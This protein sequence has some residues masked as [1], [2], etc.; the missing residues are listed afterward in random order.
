MR[1]AGQEHPDRP[2]G[3]LQADHGRS[4]AEPCGILCPLLIVALVSTTAQPRRFESGTLHALTMHQHN[5]RL[6]AR[7]AALSLVPLFEFPL[8]YRSKIMPGRLQAPTL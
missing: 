3:L 2:S 4:E 7:V 5:T 1:G 8:L 6:S